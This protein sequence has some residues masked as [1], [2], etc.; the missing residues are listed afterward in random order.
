MLAHVMDRLQPQVLGLALNA[1]GDAARF[2]AFGLP[3]IPDTIPNNPGPLA[4]ILAGLVWAARVYPSAADIV[5]IPADAPF[6]PDNLILALLEA[7]DRAGACMAIAASGGRLHP[8]IG[9]WP[10]TLA[11]SLRQAIIE[12]GTQK[13]SDFVDRQAA[14]VA[15]F[16][17]AAFDPF[18]NVNTEAD[19]LHAER[20]LAGE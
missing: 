13:V 12:D 5:T 14:A 20:F 9:L 4:G 2:A 19:R 7:R 15:D 8:V 1:N 16:P 11:T 17:A 10:V 6:I 3:V 18:H